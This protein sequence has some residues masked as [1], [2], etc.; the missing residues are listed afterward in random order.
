M[1]K[2]DSIEE[3]ID[4]ILDYAEVFY[5]DSRWEEREKIVPTYDNLNSQ[6]LS[7]IKEERQKAAVEELQKVYKEIV[8]NDI[9]GNVKWCV[10]D[11]IEQLQQGGGE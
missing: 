8:K 10:S 6:L 7:L 5:N 11:R 1:S 9:A 4:E 2:P 3:K